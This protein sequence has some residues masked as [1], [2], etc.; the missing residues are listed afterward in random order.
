MKKLVSLFIAVVMILSVAA[1]AFAVSSAD[2]AY[3]STSAVSSPDGVI[4]DFFEDLINF[5]KWLFGMDDDKAEY[6]LTFITNGGTEMA[7]M[8][9]KEGSSI[10]DPAI[11]QKTGYTFIGWTPVI[12]DKMPAYDI[13]VEAEWAVNIYTISFDSAGGSPVESI[14]ARYQSKV[15]APAD[16]AR[17]GYIFAG[18]QQYSYE[19]GAWVSAEIP[20]YMP[21]NDIQLRAAWYKL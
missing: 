5:F 3:S 2:A 15:T 11:P 7:P 16:P 21:A 18:W 12:P 17:E 10:P 19:K 14:T 4:S 6:K 8:Y 13:T 9:I 1:P 20:A